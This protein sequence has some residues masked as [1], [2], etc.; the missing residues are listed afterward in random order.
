[1]DSTSQY[2]RLFTDEELDMLERGDD[3]VVESEP[4]EYDKELEERLF[5]LDDEKILSRVKRNA[6]KQE[7]PSLADMSVQLGISEEV[8]ERTKEVSSGEMRTPEYW[9]DCR[10]NEE[11]DFACKFRALRSISSRAV[12]DL[13]D[14][15]MTLKGTGD[16]I[17]LGVTRVEETYAA[18]VT[19][20]VQL[21]PGHLA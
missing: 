1:M 2:D 3:P 5:P 9:L 14:Q 4:E 17:P 12:I 7:K 11:T 13:E 10:W 18:T 6:E 8:L 21:K 16:V 15:S 19:S 20:T